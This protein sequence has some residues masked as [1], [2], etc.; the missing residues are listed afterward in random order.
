MRLALYQG[1]SP[2]GDAEAAFSEIN[3]TLAATAAAGGHMAVMPEL[4][5][6]GYNTDPMATDADWASRL[7]DA[8]KT[9]GVGLTIGLAEMNGDKHENLA[10][11]FGPDGALLARYAKVMLFGPREKSLFELGATQVAFDFAGH[12]IGL[13]ICYDVEFPELVRA[14]ARDGVDLLLVPTGNPE[15][16]DTVCRFVVPATAAQHSLSIAYANYCGPEGDV[17][18]CGRSVIAGPDGEPLATA[19]LHTTILIAD[20]PGHDA[21]ELRPLS[22]QLED[23]GER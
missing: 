19:G 16:Y 18:Y 8:A 2:A 23:L 20:I 10:L 1:P 15:P 14:H 3:R 5:L 11:A 21:P 4:Y 17:T 6:P 12:R 7:S 9:H 13:L 22:T